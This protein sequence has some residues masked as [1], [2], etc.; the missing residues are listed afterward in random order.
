MNEPPL[1][2]VSCIEIAWITTQ[3]HL[4]QAEDF[5]SWVVFFLFVFFIWL[6]YLLFTQV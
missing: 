3:T 6:H 5:S 2:G 4:A 1:S